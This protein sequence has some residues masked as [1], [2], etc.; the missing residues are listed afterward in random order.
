MS[1]STATSNV[2]NS[3]HSPSSQKSHATKLRSTLIPVS[4]L[5]N[6]DLGQE[7]PTEKRTERGLVLPAEGARVCNQ[8]KSDS[9]ML[10]PRKQKYCCRFCTRPSPNATE[11]HRHEQSVHVRSTSWSCNNI[12]NVA[13]ALSVHPGSFMVLCGFC[14]FQI[15]SSQSDLSDQVAR[16]HLE[17]M[18]LWQGCDPRKRF[19]RP[20]HY[21]QHLRHVHGALPGPWTVAVQT[22]A[23]KRDQ[24]S[25]AS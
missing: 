25:V 2:N 11:N 15:C 8:I 22:A 5:L 18:H 12:P 3:V 19:Y 23:V 1:G 17:Q 7:T 21:Q 16:D 13:A 20:D 9:L 24:N 14:G 6:D 10:T 4:F